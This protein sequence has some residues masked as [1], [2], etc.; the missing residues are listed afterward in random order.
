MALLKKH[1][2]GVSFRSLADQHDIS[3]MTAYRKCLKALKELPHCADV[4]RKHCLKY[5][6]IFLVDGKF[7]RVKGYPSKI[8]VIYG[9]DYYTHDIP[10]YKLTVTENFLSLKVFFQSLR[11]LNYPLQALVSDDNLNIPQACLEVYP[12]T[13]WQ[14]CTNHYKENIRRSL[15]VRTDPTYQPFM[16]QIELLFRQK[17]SED[18]FNRAAKNTLHQFKSDPTCMA[19][20]IDIERRKANLTAH[21]KVKNTPQTTNLIE[22]YNSHLNGRLKTIKGFESFQHANLWLNGYFLRRRVKRLSDCRGKFKRLN[23][24]SSLQISS[25]KEVL[26]ADLFI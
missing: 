3:H 14:L 26:F 18:D 2:D 16:R 23:G 21:L 12:Q 9:I 25:L 20:L 13:A 24:K 7:L 19:I 1:L 8:P 17:R 15:A 10:T 11:L 6:G 5:S 22:S 4:T